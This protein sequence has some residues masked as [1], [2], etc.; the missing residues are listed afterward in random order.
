MHGVLRIR[1]A[2]AHFSGK[3]HHRRIVAISSWADLV[4][5]V[6][7]SRLPLQGEPPLCGRALVL[8]PWVIVPQRKF[9]LSPTRIQAR[10]KQRS[11]VLPIYR[12]RGP[13]ARNDKVRREQDDDALAIDTGPRNHGRRSDVSNRRFTRARGPWLDRAEPRQSDY[14][15]DCAAKREKCPHGSRPERCSVVVASARQRQVPLRLSR[16]RGLTPMRRPDD[17]RH[18][19][20]RRRKGEATELLA[21][22]STGGVPTPSPRFCPAGHGSRMRGCPVSAFGTGH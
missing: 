21:L 20:D 3:L 4:S 22:A 14:S 12:R 17:C 1:R 16:I 7:R 5:L 13:P 9:R 11:P 2:S 19:Q 18:S 10:F 15:A 6:S 8:G